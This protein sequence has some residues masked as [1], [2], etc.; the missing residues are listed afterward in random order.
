MNMLVP[1][2]AGL[3]AVLVMTVVIRR[4]RYLF[5]PETQMIR[6]IGSMVTKNVDT[7]LWP[8]FFIHTAVGIAFAYF[9]SYLLHTI[10]EQ[11]LAGGKGTFTMMVACGLISLVQGIIVTLFLVI[12]VAQ[13][14]PVE[15]FRKLNPG[16]MASHVIGHFFYGI[17]VGFLL[18]WLPNL[19]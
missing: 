12:A 11:L 10:P 5:L 17:T 4:A 7:A 16:D 3:V 6:A 8:G 2:I 9:Y 18:G 15:Q 19:M 1:G 14:H 13:Y